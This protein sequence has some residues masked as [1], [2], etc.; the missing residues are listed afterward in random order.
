MSKFSLEHLFPMLDGNK[1]NYL[2]FEEFAQDPMFDI[3]FNKDGKITLEEYRKA[4]NDA[5]KKVEDGMKNGSGGGPGAGS[6]AGGP[7]SGGAPAG[8][9]PQQ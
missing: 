1:D 5:G 9:P 2:S 3:D 6:P 7:P 4:N 8:G